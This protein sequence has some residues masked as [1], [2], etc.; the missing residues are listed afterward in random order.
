MKTMN[1]TITSSI[2]MQT[3]SRRP[4]VRS[5]TEMMAEMHLDSRWDAGAWFLLT[6]C[7]TAILVLCF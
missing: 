5:V 3:P 7:A 6:A 1:Q 2:P 4:G